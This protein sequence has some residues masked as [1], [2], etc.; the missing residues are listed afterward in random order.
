MTPRDSESSLPRLREVLPRDGFQDLPIRVPTSL[1]VD[2]IHKVHAVG[3]RWI[4]VTSF[5]HPRQV[6][7]FFD[8]E[9]VV[10]ATR[11]LP[12]VTVSAF[13]PNRH[14]LQR[15]M[16]AGTD[17]VSLAVATTDA[18]A[19]S[20]FRQS[21]EELITESLAVAE[22]ALGARKMV[23]ITIGGAFGCPFEGPVRPETVVEIVEQIVS[24]GVTTVL[25]ADTIGVGTPEGVGEL[26]GLVVEQLPDIEFGVHIHGQQGIDS[27]RTALDAGAT[28]VDTSMGGFG[29]CPFV[30]DAPGNVDTALVAQLLADSGQWEGP[31]PSQLLAC[32]ADVR[33]VLGPFDG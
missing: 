15:A 26:I 29:G 1:K 7:Q 21:R 12:G 28:I 2:I 8:A 33:K 16:A 11:E 25:L 14:G 4:E 31:E 5:V 3:C 18:L 10:A 22:E 19:E 6:P 30:P 24:G 23:S 17:E 20:N 27:V 32:S 13:V 9:Q